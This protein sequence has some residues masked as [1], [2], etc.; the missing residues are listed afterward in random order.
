MMN[1]FLILYTI[2]GCCKILR[3]FVCCW[4]PLFT[5]CCCCCCN[6][7]VW[8]SFLLGFVSFSSSSCL[9]EIC[10]SL[11]KQFGL[12]FFFPPPL[13]NLELWVLLSVCVFCSL[14]N[15]VVAM[16]PTLV[17]RVEAAAGGLGGVGGGVQVQ[18]TIFDTSL[19]HIPPTHAAVIL[20]SSLPNSLSRARQFAKDICFLTLLG[21]LENPFCMRN[22][23]WE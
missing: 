10:C 23:G 6:K 2:F 16:L 19:S 5:S 12:N 4:V 9:C 13:E 21:E 18:G 7:K 15:S 22:G 11:K 1:F 14:R 20:F 8:A 3:L 17:W